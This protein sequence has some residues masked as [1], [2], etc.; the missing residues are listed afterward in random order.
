MIIS[1]FALV[2]I[3]FY[4]FLSFSLYKMVES[5]TLKVSIRTIINNPEMLWFVSDHLKTEKTGKYAI[6]KF[7][8]VT[9]YGP[10]KFK[11]K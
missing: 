3:A 7:T 8:F 9:K 5:K 6:K 11:A 10:D 2:I 4:Y 1:I